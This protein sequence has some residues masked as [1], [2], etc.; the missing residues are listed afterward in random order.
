MLIA[1]LRRT[2]I[3]FVRSVPLVSSLAATPTKPNLILID[4]DDHGRAN[5]AA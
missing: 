3:P 5:L 4:S 1:I 2:L